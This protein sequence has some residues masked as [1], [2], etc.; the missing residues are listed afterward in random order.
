MKKLNWQKVTRQQA[1]KTGT[2]WDK[3]ISPLEGTDSRLSIS[4]IDIEELFS[5]PVIEKRK[6]GET[7]EAKGESSKSSIVSL[8]DPKTSLNVNIFLRQFKMP[9]E[10]L[11]AIIHEGD[12][13]KISLDQLKALFKLLPDKSTVSIRSLLSTPSSLFFCPVFSFSFPLHSLFSLP[14]ILYP[15]T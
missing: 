10:K 1:V 9:N 7:E 8:L 2:I 5:R 14:Y 6:K 13:S 4:A 3:V 15:F 11:V 12:C